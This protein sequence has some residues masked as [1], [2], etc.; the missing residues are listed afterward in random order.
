MAHEDD[1]S[2]LVEQL[3]KQAYELGRV[4]G[5]LE[6][7]L[8]LHHAQVD[9]SD[10]DEAPPTAIQRRRGIPKGALQRA[11]IEELAKCDNLTNVELAL[12]LGANSESVRQSVVRLIKAGQVRRLEGA[13]FALHRNDA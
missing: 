7:H 6:F 8:R 2:A 5:Q 13:K 3:V 1:V 4:R 10:D 11:I 12:R 9:G